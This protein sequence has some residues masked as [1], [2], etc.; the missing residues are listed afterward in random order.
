MT[1]YVSPDP[2]QIPCDVCNIAAVL[3]SE[4]FALTVFTRTVENNLPSHRAGH[5]R[6]LPKEWQP[7]MAYSGSPMIYNTLLASHLYR[8]ELQSV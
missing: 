4:T 5:L 7:R 2:F 6:T 1:E 3:L 8:T